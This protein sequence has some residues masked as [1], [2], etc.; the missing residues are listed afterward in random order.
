MMAR[1]ALDAEMSRKRMRLEIEE[2]EERIQGMRMTRL[3]D[4]ATTIERLNMMDER[5][6]LRLR[7]V[8]MNV[9]GSGTGD[10]EEK[11]I[12]ISTV[13][14]EEGYTRLTDSDLIRVGGAVSRIYEEEHGERPPKHDQLVNGAVRKVCSYTERDRPLI[15]RALREYART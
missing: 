5:M 1:A 15:V 12:T 6:K 10:V 4:F 2:T 14:A 9:L 3:S 11:P 7:D 8:F 13:A